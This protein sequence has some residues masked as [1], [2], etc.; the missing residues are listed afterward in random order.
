MTHPPVWSPVW[1]VTNPASGSNS[2]AAVEALTAALA[3]ARTLAFPNDLL[4]TRADLEEAGVGTLAVFTGDGTIN[5]AAA[6]LEGWGGALLVLPGGTQNLLSKS[7]HG[8]R[9]LD[10]IL[11]DLPRANRT[12]RRGIRTSQGMSLIEVLAGPGAM[13]ADVRESVRDLDLGAMAETFSNAL[14]ET[15]EGPAVHLSDPAEGKPEGYRAILLAPERDCVLV[16]GYDF[17]DIGEFAAQGF[18]MLV[19]RN[20][21]EGPHDDIGIF[22]TVTVASDAPIALM[23]DG[24]RRQGE[25]RESFTCEEFALDF[26]ATAKAD[27]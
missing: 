23:I 16:E 9:P 4:P 14:R 6:A 27:S 13:W 20:F 10:A 24:E 22:P 7:L 12:R 21:R 17:A 5:S 8:D 25:S 11:A 15:R 26:L 19:K 1:L 3:P 2:P 18:A